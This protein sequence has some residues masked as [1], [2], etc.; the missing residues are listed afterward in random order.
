M[1]FQSDLIIKTAIE[2]GIQ[3][4]RDNLWLIDDMLSDAVDNVYLQKKYGTNQVQA[5]KEWFLNNQIDIYMRGRN[6][7]DRYPNIT[8][9]LGTSQEKSE[10]ESLGQASWETVT[11]LPNQIGKTIPYVM[12]PFEPT[13]YDPSTGEVMVSTGTPGLGNVAPGMMLVDPATGNGYIIQ[14]LLPDGFEL[15]ISLSLTAATYVVLPKN[16]FYK[17]RRE[18]SFFQETYNISCNVHGD[19]QTLLWLHSIV[20]YSMLRYRESLFEANGFAESIISSSDLQENP[21]FMGP[22]GE[23]AFS[24]VL[25]LTG[26][27]ENSWIKSPRR[28]IEKV[29]ANDPAL[30]NADTGFR[31]GIKIIS[32]LDSQAQL[33]TPSDPWTTINDDG[34]DE[35][36]QS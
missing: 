11:L 16:Q 30:G 3:D 2:L 33:D 14:G 5:C 32:N 18:H 24:R 6:D 36:E 17:A 35:E 19:E 9:T 10:M 7:R 31:G 4:M 21:A 15:E 28:V 8:I 23:R 29:V 22:G 13:N 27:V 20:L 26:Q 12:A 25:T 1:I 34:G